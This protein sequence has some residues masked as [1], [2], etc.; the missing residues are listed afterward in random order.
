MSVCICVDLNPTVLECETKLLDL[1]L[2]TSL[3]LISV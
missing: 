2:L 3:R 1:A